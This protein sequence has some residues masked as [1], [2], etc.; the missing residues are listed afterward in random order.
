LEGPSLTSLGGV[1]PVA[2]LSVLGLLLHA[3][4]VTNR[5][6]ATNKGKQKRK[7]ALKAAYP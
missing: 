2:G 7:P 3:A 6:L 1:E 4:K 5:L